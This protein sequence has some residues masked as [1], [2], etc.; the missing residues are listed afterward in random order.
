MTEIINVIEII[1]KEIVSIRSFVCYFGAKDG[2]R[3]K[4]E[5]LFSELVRENSNIDV[6]QDAMDSYIEDGR[7]YKYNYEVQII[8]SE[9]IN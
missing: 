1:D 5:D 9:M 8:W 2:T 4:A 6:E 7:Y 3:K